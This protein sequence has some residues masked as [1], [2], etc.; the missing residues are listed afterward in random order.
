MLPPVHILESQKNPLFFNYEM[1][2]IFVKE[3]IL[4]Q[5]TKNVNMDADID[6]YT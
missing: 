4:K 2:Q 3:K 1:L 6:F 5:A